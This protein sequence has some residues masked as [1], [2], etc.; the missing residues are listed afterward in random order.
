[1]TEQGRHGNVGPGRTRRALEMWR[2]SRSRPCLCFLGSPWTPSLWSTLCSSHAAT[3]A[4]DADAVPCE[5]TRSRACPNAHSFRSTATPPHRV[6]YS[7]SCLVRRPTH[8]TPSNWPC[9]P[10]AGPAARP[11]R[12]FYRFCFDEGSARAVRVNA[13]HRAQ[14]QGTPDVTYKTR[15]S[16]NAEGLT[17]SHL[18]GLKGKNIFIRT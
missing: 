16:T 1:M 13:I 17:A 8:A 7:T 10:A 18:A 15:G 12:P 6:V 4:W 9:V 14:F 5:A 3:H 11:T 2:R